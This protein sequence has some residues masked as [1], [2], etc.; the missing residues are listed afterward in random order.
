MHDGTVIVVAGG[1]SS[2][3]QALQTVASGNVGGQLHADDVILLYGLVVLVNGSDLSLQPTG[4]GDLHTQIFGRI[5]SF[6]VNIICSKFAGGVI[7]VDQVISI[8]IGELYLSASRGSGVD[9][10]VSHIQSHVRHGNGEDVFLVHAAGLGQLSFVIA[11][12]EGGD[13]SIGVGLS[14]FGSQGVSTL[15]GTILSSEGNHHS[16]GG[17]DGHIFRQFPSGLAGYVIR[18]SIADDFFH[19]NNRTLTTSIVN[20]HASNGR[21]G[22]DHNIHFLT[23]CVDVAVVVLGQHS[24]EAGVA[25]SGSLSGIHADVLNAGLGAVF[26]LDNQVVSLNRFAIA[27]GNFAP[28]SDGDSTGPIGSIG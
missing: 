17:V 25:G 23:F 8:A 15:G 7:A 3:V 21:N 9:G 5:H 28:T 19:I 18:V 11:N 1:L 24:M 20:L 13:R 14:H 6:T 26:Q 4:G 2:E 22:A 16:A 27:I 12:V 10:Q